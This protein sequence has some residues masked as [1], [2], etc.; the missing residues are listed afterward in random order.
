M[1]G[2]QNP[3]EV[4]R[5]SGLKGPALKIAELRDLMSDEQIVALLT[6]IRDFQKQNADNYKI[7][8][9]NQQRSIE[10]QQKAVTRQKGALIAVFVVIVLVVALAV[11]AV[12]IAARVIH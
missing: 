2:A 10:M 6:E 8:L 3:W 9:E 1:D 5:R 4:A 7:A 12:L 11:V